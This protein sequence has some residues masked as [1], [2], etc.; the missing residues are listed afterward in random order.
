[1]ATKKTEIKEWDSLNLKDHSDGDTV[2]YLPR[3]NP[4]PKLPPSKLTGRVLSGKGWLTNFISP[5]ITTY[6]KS[7]YLVM[8]WL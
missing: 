6:N 2:N 4:A 3:S 5:E 8:P 1:M 7:F